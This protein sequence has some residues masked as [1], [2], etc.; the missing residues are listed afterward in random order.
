MVAHLRSYPGI[1][2]N[3]GPS[4]SCLAMTSHC[5]ALMYRDGL[6]KKGCCYAVR[7]C[8]LCFSCWPVC[9]PQS[10]LGFNHLVS[11]RFVFQDISR[12]NACSTQEIF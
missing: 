3:M 12:L 6:A 8:M 2:A 11:T 1:E 5:T 4:G 7:P 9:D 10:C